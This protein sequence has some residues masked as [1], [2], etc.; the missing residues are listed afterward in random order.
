VLRELKSLKATLSYDGWQ[1]DAAETEEARDLLLTDC[2]F[3]RKF[4]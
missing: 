4:V 2:M 3:D 1:E